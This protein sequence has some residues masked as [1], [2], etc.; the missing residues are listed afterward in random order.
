MN[1]SDAKAIR[2]DRKPRRRVGRGRASGHGKTSGRGVKGAAARSGWGGKPMYRGGQTPL[3][4]RLPKRG[5]TNARYRK[6]YA[7][8]NVGRLNNLPDGTEVSPLLLLEQGVIKHVLD[9]VKVLG[10]GE[11]TKKLVV[12]AHHFSRSATQ[13]IEGAGGSVVVID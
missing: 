11:L 8:V 5:F 6:V 1:L 7:V 12:K 9:G 3:F 4:L 2:S 10:D 13:K